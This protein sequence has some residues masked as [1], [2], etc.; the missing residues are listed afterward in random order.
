MT[1]FLYLDTLFYNNRVCNI[2]FNKMKWNKNDVLLQ[3]LRVHF[4]HILRRSISAVRWV[5]HLL[6]KWPEYPWRTCAFM[7]RW[8][9]FHIPQETPLSKYKSICNQELSGRKHWERT[10]EWHLRGNQRHYKLLPFPQVLWLV[11]V[12]YRK[13]EQ[14]FHHRSLFIQVLAH[15]LIPCL[16]AESCTSNH[17][18]MLRVHSTSDLAQSWN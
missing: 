2:R 15:M 9:F 14:Q 18:A 7:L 5:G 3:P 17:F 4:L 12:S 1:T 13:R 6:Q 8:H 10:K 16:S 11:A